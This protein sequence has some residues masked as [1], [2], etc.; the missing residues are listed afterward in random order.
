MTQLS[1]VFSDG[2]PWTKRAYHFHKELGTQW[3]LKAL[4][5]FVSSSFCSRA[6]SSLS[7]TSSLLLFNHTSHSDIMALIT[8]SFWAYFHISLHKRTSV[9]SVTSHCAGVIWRCN[10][11]NL[12]NMKW[13]HQTYL[14]L[15]C[16]ASITS[17]KR[18]IKESHTLKHEQRSKPNCKLN[19]L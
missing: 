8:H 14:T 5:S 10:D 2:L 3:P 1:S 17:W 13:A 9:L 4:W 6:L 11:T 18:H 7:F 15:A 19:G 16:H 12:I